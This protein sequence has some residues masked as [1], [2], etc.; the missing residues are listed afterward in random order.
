M[1]ILVCIKQVPD[2]ESKFN[3]G[4]DGTWYD[5]A[6]L[7]W[8][9]NEYD[10]YAVEQAVQLKEKT[11]ADLTVLCIGAERVKET[12]KKALAMGC[13]RGVHVV[14]EVSYKKDPFSIAAI[15][16]EFAGRKNFDLIFTGMQSQDRG[17]AQV[18][19]LVAEMLGMPCVTTIVDFSFEGG[20]ITVKREL[21]GGAKA[22]VTASI[23]AL[24]TCQLGLNSPRYLTLPN[25]LKAKKKE[26]LSIPVA[27]LLKAE[28]LEE[29]TSL[30][31]PE[32]KGTGLILE[33]DASDL[34]DRLIKILKEKT[35]VLA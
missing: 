4:G 24:V 6:D 25:I 15:I 29:T 31:F 27:D 14:D 32:K 20:Q 1:K 2:M 19:V 9:M 12:M 21:E 28:V 3:V 35:A 26:L 23:P 34:A 18:G 22:K 7:A 8:R 10:E 13:D 33:G 30:Y 11:G 16:A 17:S 5:G